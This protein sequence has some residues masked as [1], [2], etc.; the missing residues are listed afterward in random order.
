VH[1]IMEI[2]FVEA[3]GPMVAWAEPTSFRTY[4]SLVVLSAILGTACSSEEV[5]D[6][7]SSSEA[8][9]TAGASCM[10]APF[11]NERFSSRV[12]A[13]GTIAG[14]DVCVATVKDLVYFSATKP[15][16][17]LETHWDVRNANLGAWA[18][19]EPDGGDQPDGGDPWVVAPGVREED[20]GADRKSPT[21]QV[22]EYCS[23]ERKYRGCLMVAS[24]VPVGA[25]SKAVDPGTI[26][27]ASGC[28]LGY[29]ELSQTR[30]FVTAGFHAG[31]GLQPAPIA[32]SCYQD[33]RDA[34]GK[35]GIILTEKCGAEAPRDVGC[36]VR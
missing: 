32:Q 30:R 1:D 36:I 5:A 21:H 34:Y 4:A 3:D 23:S 7:E 11:K 28:S 15:G 8:A 17:K 35:L 26:T 27:A 18:K 33:D 19:D 2:G 24:D 31:K 25:K 6:D 14:K 12:N 22:R 16:C 9:V 29:L 13:Q 20:C 10:I